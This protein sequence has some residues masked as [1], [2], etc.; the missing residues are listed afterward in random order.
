M[1]AVLA[2]GPQAVLS[3]RSAAALWGVR[4]TAGARV[5]VTAPRRLRPRPNLLPHFA[6]LPSDQRTTQTGI[7]VTTPARTLLDLAAVL[8]SNELDRA[9]NEAEIQRLSGPNHLIAG[10]RGTTALRA[11]L[12]D[13]RR[14]SRSP[15]EAEF[16]AFVRAHDLPE[17]ETN[18]IIE[19]YEADFV[20]RAQKLIVELDGFATHGTRTAFERDRERDRRLMAGGWKTARVTRAQLAR[21]AELAQELLSCIRA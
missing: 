1:A 9:L 16:L 2:C 5:E 21:P 20:W 15:L 4:P 6:V 8:K 12:L 10:Q 7:P 18:T 19:G 17:P 3:H 13:A 14:S 11:L